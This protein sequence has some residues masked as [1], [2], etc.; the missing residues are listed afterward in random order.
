MSAGEILKTI[1]AV[2]GLALGGLSFT[3]ATALTIGRSE[4]AAV[5]GKLDGHI[6]GSL[7]VHAAQDDRLKQLQEDT[8]E[9]KRAAHTAA[10]EARTTRQAV[11]RL[12]RGRR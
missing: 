6:A 1:G 11:E 2:G 10:E 7:Q 4:V 12:E 5:S 3:W 9:S 8:S